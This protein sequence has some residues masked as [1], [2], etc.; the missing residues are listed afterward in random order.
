[1]TPE[2]HPRKK[3]VMETLLKTALILSQTN[4][5]SE[6]RKYHSEIDAAAK[7]LTKFADGLADAN[8]SVT[9]A[10]WWYMQLLNYVLPDGLD[11]DLPMEQKGQ[12]ANRFFDCMNAIPDFDSYQQFLAAVL[13][14]RHRRLMMPRFNRPDDKPKDPATLQPRGQELTEQAIRFLRH[15][16]R[17]TYMLTGKTVLSSLSIETWT[18]LTKNQMFVAEDLCRILLPQSVADT[19]DP[20]EM[21]VYLTERDGLF[22]MNTDVCRELMDTGLTKRFTIISDAPAQP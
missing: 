7:L 13:P 5:L 18:T 16:A 15:P 11:K 9:T 12:I 1:M 22:D 10:N 17:V 21:S 6:L 3:S 2:V 20:V 19:N 14:E 8:P 4:S